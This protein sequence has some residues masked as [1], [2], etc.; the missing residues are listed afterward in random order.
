MKFM[1]LLKK[2]LKELLTPTT[3]VILVLCVFGLTAL[4]SIMDSEIEK[5][6]EETGKI[7][8]CDQDKGTFSS[9]I[10]EAMKAADYEINEVELTGDDY[11]KQL[12][13]LDL[14]SVV[15]IPQG[16]EQ[17]MQ[18]IIT[19][20]EGVELKPVNIEM[21]SRL[22]SLS[23]TGNMEDG[24]MMATTAIDSAVKTVVYSK[25]GVTPEQMLMLEAPV[26][27]K[28]TTIVG[29]KQAEAS[30]TMLSAYVMM[31]SM[32]V[33]IVIFLL[34]IYSSQMIMNAVATEKI[35]KTLETLLSAPISRL[36]V[37]LAKMTA[38]SV[39]SA[40]YAVAF[41]IGFKD[42]MGVGGMTDT[43]SGALDSSVVSQLGLDL[44]MGGYIMLVA[45]M[46]L[47]LLITLAVSLILGAL[48]KDAKSSQTLLLPI[49]GM[50]MIPY[51]IS[52][53]TDIS[54][55]GPFKWVL[56]AIP[57]SHTF[58][59]QTNIILN[60]MPAYFG[61]LIYQLILLIICM[62]CAVKMFT[63]DKIFTLTLNFGERKNKYA[64]ARKKFGV[65]Q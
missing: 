42:M 61:G 46:F 65:K 64:K 59:A 57:Y 9:A 58:M 27:L 29:D 7:N 8:I 13:D 44:S 17:Q 26:S 63:S 5:S 41:L 52:M 31:S 20:G 4:G 12:K 25:M 55:L 33:P 53:F 45:Q 47:S 56:Y 40:L 14:T 35:D 30:A 11:V 38:A 28:E 19:S 15:I 21:V 2:E 16:F 23:L 22:E 37:L 51:M 43:I 34:I 50:V 39:V 24:S 54:A 62:G 32:F 10:I 3:I 36:S 6:S 48:A 49:M 1:Y 18:D 60:D